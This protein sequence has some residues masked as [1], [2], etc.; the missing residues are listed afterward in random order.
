VFLITLLQ[1]LGL[2]R[3]DL[4]RH[5]APGGSDTGDGSPAAPY[6]TLT[7]ALADAAQLDED[8]GLFVRVSGAAT[9]PFV[10]SLTVPSRVT[11]E[12][13]AEARPLLR[14]AQAGPAIRVSGSGDARVSGVHLRNLEISGAEPAGGGG[15][16]AV[17]LQH[18]DDVVLSNCALT[19]TGGGLAIERCSAIKL[20]GCRLRASG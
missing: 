13:P 6:R 17:V 7:R 19:G 9:Q 10:E 15:A 8:Q 2:V 14:A 12:G 3:S 5:V 4:E 11:L 1:A 20:Q 16:H 18:A